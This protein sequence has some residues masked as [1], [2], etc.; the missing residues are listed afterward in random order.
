MI[1]DFFSKPLQGAQ[2]EKF[3]DM[4]LNIPKPWTRRGVLRFL[5]F[6]FQVQVY[7]FRICIFF[8]S[9]ILFVY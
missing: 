9:F 2:F 3:R 7:V 6:F 1:A 8:D 4:I 5:L